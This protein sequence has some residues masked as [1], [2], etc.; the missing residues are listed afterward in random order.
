MNSPEWTICLSTRAE[1]ARARAEAEGQD[2]TATLQ[3]S[4][5]ATKG[6][7]AA[8]EPPTPIR[9]PKK[10]PKPAEQPRL[11]DRKGT[12]TDGPAPAAEP[13]PYIPLAP[14][15]QRLRVE[16]IPAN[17]AVKEI[18]AFIA[19]DPGTANWSADA[20]QDLVSTILIAQFSRRIHRV[21]GARMTGAERSAMRYRAILIDPSD[22]TQERPKQILGNDRQEIDR[23]A[24]EV[25]RSAGSSA[26]VNVYQMVEQ[27]IAIIPKEKA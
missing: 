24:A 16:P 4:L 8:V 2:L 13:M 22:T 9:T 3:A 23:W 10:E 14:A 18:L 20:R 27:Q 19:A 12:G 15:R 25:L 1:N 26:M 6:Q 7:K 5:E 11:F 17:V 21:V